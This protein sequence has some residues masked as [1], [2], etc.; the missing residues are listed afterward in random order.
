VAAYA[1]VVALTS[2][3]AAASK[4]WVMLRVLSMQAAVRSAHAA[5]L[6]CRKWRKRKEAS[7]RRSA[8]RDQASTT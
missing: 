8:T 4:M 3:R 2:P 5:A 1:R 6:S 7:G